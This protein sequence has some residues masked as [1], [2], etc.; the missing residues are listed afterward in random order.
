MT[1]IEWTDKTWNPVTGCTEIS[2]GCDH[3][4][5]KRLAE[6]FRDTPAIPSKTASTSPCAPSGCPSRFSGRSLA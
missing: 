4:Y 6:R 5:A 2:R 3:C 1:K